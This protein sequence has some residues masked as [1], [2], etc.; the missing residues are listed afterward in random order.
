MDQ[1]LLHR[2]VQRHL[3]HRVTAAHRAVRHPL[4]PLVYMDSPAGLFHGAE[5]GLEVR[6]GQLVQRDVP[7]AG[8]QVV[9]DPSLVT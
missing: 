1:P 4:S 8:D 9:V 6:L 7:H 5:E 2:L 3:A